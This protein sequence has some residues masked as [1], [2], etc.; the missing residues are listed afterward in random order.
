MADIKKITEGMRGS[1][2]SDLLDNNFKG[3]D[4]DIKDLGTTSKD[5]LD[6]LQEQ[7]NKRGYVVLGYVDSPAKTRES[8]PVEIRKL[9]LTITY[10]PGNSWIQEQFIG[11][12]T[13]DAEWGKGEYW[14]SIG[15]SGSGF[16]VE[17]DTEF[18]DKTVAHNSIKENER[19]TGMYM[20]YKFVGVWTTEQYVGA[21]TSKTNWDN[22]DNWKLLIYN[23]QMEEIALRAQEAAETALKN[24]LDAIEI[25]NE[26]GNEAINN[27]NIAGEHAIQIA[28]KAANNTNAAI[29]A[30]NNATTRANAA[31]E[32]VENLIVP[33]FP[34]NTILR[35]TDEAGNIFGEKWLPC[36]G[37]EVSAAKYPDLKV[38]LSASIWKDAG[39]IQE[40]NIKNAIYG[41][42]TYICLAFT[43]TNANKANIYSSKDLST[44]NKRLELDTYGL[45]GFNVFFLNGMFFCFSLKNDYSVIDVYK[46][47][48]GIEWNKTA[49]IVWEGN[50][51]N[52]T[53]KQAVYANGRYIISI[54]VATLTSSDGYE[55]KKND[56]GKVP[57][58][59]ILYG[60]GV[61]IVVTH[62]SNNVV[63]AINWSENG[64]IWTQGIVN[65]K[66]EEDRIYNISVTFDSDK[67]VAIATESDDTLLYMI[68]STDGKTWNHVNF[69][70]SN[71]VYNIVYG[72][73][74]YVCGIYNGIIWSEDL[75]S[76]HEVLLNGDVA[77]LIFENGVFYAD[78]VID[79]DT[80]NSY[81]S[82]DGKIWNEINTGLTKEPGNIV[83]S[84]TNIIALE[85]SNP[86]NIKKLPIG[87]T[88]PTIENHYIK[89]VK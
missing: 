74:V 22:L 45:I 79:S 66:W 84:D 16:W 8:V 43:K 6:T 68:M 49:E 54:H 12:S 20:S 72:N 87:K 19:Q 11:T 10:N 34:V 3:L 61:F 78:A 62:P 36:D 31:A 48:D 86:I 38:M 69:N 53:P 73:G 30:A 47:Q 15:G 32:E 52:S 42:G 29:E 64:E 33:F 81:M 18:T 65:G 13:T 67:F 7:L 26:K 14:K 83:I 58:G 2:V 41:N 85:G 88:L 1:E 76:W 89:A 77:F 63:S 59:E 28:Q 37:R 56:M 21:D 35:T 39:T 23:E 44:W 57:T 4:A 27:A 24:G 17:S 9:G 40:G 71:N 25:A 75:I 55:W 5:A 46:S 51:N 60:N 50:P 80:P 82:N 70:G